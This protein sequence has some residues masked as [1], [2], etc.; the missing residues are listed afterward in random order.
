MSAEGSILNDMI[1]SE[2]F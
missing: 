1:W 2:K